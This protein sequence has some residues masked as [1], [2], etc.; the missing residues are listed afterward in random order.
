[1][2]YLVVRDFERAL[3]VTAYESQHNLQLYKS[4]CGENCLFI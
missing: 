3:Y 4:D 2:T 1:M